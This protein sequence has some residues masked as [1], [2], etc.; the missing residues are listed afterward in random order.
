MS[1]V[2]SKCLIIAELSRGIFA[3]L[4]SMAL[5]RLCVAA[6][7]SEVFSGHYTEFADAIALLSAEAGPKVSEYGYCVLLSRLPLRRFA[8]SAL[9]VSCAIRRDAEMHAILSMVPE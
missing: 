2:N 5:P 9:G 1:T 7:Q 3:A 8:G 4:F 6:P